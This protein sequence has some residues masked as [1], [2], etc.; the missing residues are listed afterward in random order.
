MSFDLMARSDASYSKSVPF[1]EASRV[2]AKVLGVPPNPYGYGLEEGAD[3]CM[4]INLLNGKSDGDDHG[5]PQE[6][7]MVLFNVP[8]AMMGGVERCVDVAL[9]IADGLGWELYDPQRD[10]VF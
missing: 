4:D 6:I 9:Q 1:E 7:D 8:W 2:V 10:E 3:V 5:P